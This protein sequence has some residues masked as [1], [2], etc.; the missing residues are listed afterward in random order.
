MD[1]IDTLRQLFPP[2]SQRPLPP[3]V[4]EVLRVTARAWNVVPPPPRLHAVSRLI[5]PLR[6]TSGGAVRMSDTRGFLPP[7]VRPHP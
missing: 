2:A 1:S 3:L 5:A 4:R 7:P 6:P